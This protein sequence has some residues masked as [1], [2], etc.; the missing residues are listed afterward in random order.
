MRETISR[1]YLD[2]DFAHWFK[3]YSE[4]YV[5]W[6]NFG[7]RLDHRTKVCSFL[8]PNSQIKC[9]QSTQKHSME[10]SPDWFEDWLLLRAEEFGDLPIEPNFNCQT[11]DC[12][13]VKVVKGRWTGHIT[14]GYV[15]AV[16][17]YTKFGRR[18]NW[19][20]NYPTNSGVNVSRPW[21]HGYDVKSWE[22][23]N[24]ICITRYTTISLTLDFDEWVEYR[25]KNVDDETSICFIAINY[26]DALLLDEVWSKLC[27]A[28]CD[29]IQQQ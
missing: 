3:F 18:S 2:D 6:Y 12:Q 9:L 28:R 24:M 8:A 20:L 1:Q 10:K 16:P 29:D 17:N 7:G 19:K 26:I 25:D 5:L 4:Y 15:I 11:H 14:S 21:K 22:A 13:K 27:D 23:W